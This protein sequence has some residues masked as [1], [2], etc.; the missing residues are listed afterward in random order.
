[1]FKST[2]LCHVNILI[3]QIIYYWI[4]QTM[5][6]SSQPDYSGTTNQILTFCH[7]CGLRATYPKHVVCCSLRANDSQLI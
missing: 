1:M 5:G 7:L 2:M 3:Q 6:M 4:N